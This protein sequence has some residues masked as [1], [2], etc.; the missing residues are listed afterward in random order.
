MKIIIYANL[1]RYDQMAFIVGARQ[2]GKNTI[3]KRLQSR[4]KESICLGT[5]Q[6]CSLADTFSCSRSF[7]E[8]HA[9]CVHES[10]L[11]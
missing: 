2:V 3:A 10:P 6:N 1:H 5:E 8:I 11:Q 4:F 7:L 9:M